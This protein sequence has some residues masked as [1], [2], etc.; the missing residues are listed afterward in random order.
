MCGLTRVNRS[1]SKLKLLPDSYPLLTAFLYEK[2]YNKN[3]K[4]LIVTSLLI[5][6]LIVVGVLLYVTRDQG[7]QNP[8]DIPP[9]LNSRLTPAPTVPLG[10]SGSSFLDPKG[11]FTVLYPSEYEL[12]T[13]DPVHPRIFKRGETQ[14]PQSEIYDGALIV[15]ESVDLGNQNLSSWIDARIKDATENGMQEVIKPKA[16]ASFN[17]FPGY[18]YTLRGLGETTYTAIQKDSSSKNAVII[19]TL[20]ADPENKGYQAEVD[21]T[22]NSITLLK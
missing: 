9:V 8:N 5:I 13:S 11:V 6:L 17:N 18:S 14:R 3:V 21:A 19:S 10:A 15:F 22:L 4:K 1:I 16:A 2:I 12:D 20:V 7:I